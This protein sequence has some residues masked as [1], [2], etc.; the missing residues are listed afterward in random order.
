MT[1]FEEHLKQAMAR[2][3][4]AAD[5]T[6]RLLEQVQ[7]EERQRAESGS[8]AWFRKLRTSFEVLRVWRLAGVAAA[9]L[10]ISG[11]A[12][13]EHQRT[14]RGEAAKEK[15]LTA[16]RIAGVKLHQVHRQVLEVEAM[17]A[18]Q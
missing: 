17:E 15:L 18:N 11:S 1:P 13:Y 6:Q 12:M 16:V 7:R 2:R 10:A 9:L 3:E 4:P 5:F 14:V 8:R